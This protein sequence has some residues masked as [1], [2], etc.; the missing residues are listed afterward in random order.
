MCTS[1][2]LNSMVSVKVTKYLLQNPEYKG[3]KI[4]CSSLTDQFHG[5]GVNEK[6]RHIVRLHLPVENS[7]HINRC[8]K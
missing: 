3:Q 7:S 1:L 8:A 6:K 4:K 5:S 2:N